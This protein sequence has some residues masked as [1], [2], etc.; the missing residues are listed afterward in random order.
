M[1]STSLVNPG[2]KEVHTLGGDG[3]GEA[4]GW[5]T[6]IE[7]VQKVLE[8]LFRIRP[9]A[10]DVVNVSFPE[11]RLEGLTFKESRLNEM[12]SIMKDPTT[13]TLGFLRGV[14]GGWGRS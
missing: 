9:N 4:N 3:P 12:V 13:Q 6:G 7:S 8:G 10:E 5:M 14:V 2:V 1:E 11:G